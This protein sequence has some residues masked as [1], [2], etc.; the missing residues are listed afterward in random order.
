[1]GTNC[2][3]TTHNGG[4]L[5]RLPCLI[6]MCL[7]SLLGAWVNSFTLYIFSQIKSHFTAS[8]KFLVTLIFGQLLLTLFVGPYHILVMTDVVTDYK[9][10]TDVI[11]D[12]KSM[13]DTMRDDMQ[14]TYVVRNDK[15]MTGFIRD[16]KSMLD[17]MA[18]VITNN[19]S[20]TEV[21]GDDNSI[22]D[23]KTDTMTHGK[24]IN[25]N[26]RSTEDYADSLILISVVSKGVVSY[27]RYLHVALAHRYMVKIQ[28]FFLY[29]LLSLPWLSMFIHIV[30]ITLGE[31]LSHGLLILIAVILIIT[32]TTNYSRLMQALNVPTITVSGAIV[33]GSIRKKR[34]T[35]VIML[36]FLILVVEFSCCIPGM[37]T[38]VS[39]MYYFVSGRRWMF[40]RENWNTMQ[41]V[42]LIFLLLNACV[43]PLVYLHSHREIREFIKHK[44]FRKRNMVGQALDDFVLENEQIAKKR[45]GSLP[46]NILSRKASALS[47]QHS[48]QMISTKERSTKPV[49]DILTTVKERI[50]EPMMID[51]KAAE[52]ENTERQCSLDTIDETSVQVKFDRIFTLTNFG[53]HVKMITKSNRRRSFDVRKVDSL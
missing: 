26:V 32:L 17:A 5:P 2:V 51:V 15:S 33:L 47:D 52:P 44:I 1:M 39:A 43:N 38:I 20:I 4:T 29:L 14:T 22:S 30:C 12:D 31:L 48:F 42:S 10:I 45:S 25:C 16:D 6:L 7:L 13:T 3:P 36:C 24:S 41:D 21:M 50:K 23:T 34:N 9:S 40:W 18:N 37:V 35:K 28:G 46:V 27:D 19:K 8:N 11:K 53:A 49:F